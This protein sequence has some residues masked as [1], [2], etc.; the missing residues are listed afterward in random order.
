MSD[1]IIHEMKSRSRRE[2]KVGHGKGLDKKFLPYTPFEGSSSRDIKLYNISTRK[3][4]IAAI[5]RNALFSASEWQI[6]FYFFAV[7]SSA[8]GCSVIKQQ[9]RQCT[10]TTL[11]LTPLNFY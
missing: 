11:S 8:L 6:F 3:V 5:Y 1:S 10:S 7:G 2:A 4:S 9:I